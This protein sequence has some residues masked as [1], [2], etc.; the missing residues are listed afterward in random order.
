M[1]IHLLQDNTIVRN[2]YVMNNNKIVEFNNYVEKYEKISRSFEEQVEAE[3]LTIDEVREKRK[4]MTKKLEKLVLEIHPY[5]FKQMTGKD[6]R[7]YTSVKEEGKER[8]IIKKNTYEE[9]IDYLIDFYKIKEVKQLITLRTMYPIWIEYKNS[10]T[11]K[12]STIRRIEADWKKYYKNDPIS[13]VPL[14][15]MSKNQ[16]TEWL[17]K[18]IIKDGLTNK[19]N[20]Y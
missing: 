13:D 8:K 9:L 15:K 2:G 19:K 10:C 11:Q 17:N 16:I 14:E 3:I 4:E 1:I 5:A 6:T 18:R 20:F 12:T 7:W